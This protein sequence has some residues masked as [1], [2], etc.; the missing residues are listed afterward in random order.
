MSLVDDVFGSLAG[1]LIDEWGIAAVYIKHNTSQVYSPATGTFNNATDPAT[2]NPAILTTRI[3][4]RVLPTRLT[5][6]DIKGEV[7]STDVKFLMAPDA[8][9]NYYPAVMDMIE[10][11]QAGVTRTARIVNPDAIRGDFP[12]FHSIIA[13]IG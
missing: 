13:R 5:A 8:L 1:P 4:V 3:N 10:Y 11:T 6:E 12:V 2:G 9:G 7:Q